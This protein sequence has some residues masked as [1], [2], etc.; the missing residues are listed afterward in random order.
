MYEQMGVKV[1][2][3]V[4]KAV[5]N[6]LRST[7][8]GRNLEQVVEA[9]LKAWLA[10]ATVAN[11]KAAVAA[12]R[13]YQWKSLFLPEGS[14][15]RVAVGG[16]Y[17]VAT[18]CGDHIMFEGLSY[19]PRQFVMHITGQVRNAWLAVWIR[20]PGDARWH[21]A[22]T[23]RRILRRVPA[24]GVTPAPATPSAASAPALLPHEVLRAH[25][26]RSYLKRGDCVLEEQ[27]DLSIR[28]PPGRGAGPYGAGRAGPR[29]RRV[30]GSLLLQYWPPRR[31]ANPDHP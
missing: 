28:I 19:S 2:A 20:C 6:L 24:A 18:V 17:S 31:D 5:D 22:D 29:D 11:P 10:A 27:A 23:R 8:D 30:L 1:S 15:L 9:A 12:A 26:R 3:R 16:R 4:R 21:V 14:L 13:G 25:R 7:G